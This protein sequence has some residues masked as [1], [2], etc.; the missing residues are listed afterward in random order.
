ML[1]FA[2]LLLGSSISG[3]LWYRNRIVATVVLSVTASGVIFYLLF[4]IAGSLCYECPYQ[5]PMSLIIRIIV[6]S[7][8]PRVPLV[9]SVT[10][11]F[12]G[13]FSWL[14]TRLDRIFRSIKSVIRRVPAF[15]LVLRHNPSVVDEVIIVPAPLFGD[16]LVNWQ[17]HKEDSKCVLW[18]MDTSADADVLLFAFRCAAD[19]V[20]Y[21]EIATLLCSRRVAALFFDCFLDGAVIPGAEE[22]ASYLA[23]ILTSILNIHACMGYNLEAT[24]QI[25]EGICSLQWEH[26]DPDVYIAWWSLTLTFHEQVLCCPPLR[27]D[28]SPGF[29]I[30]LSQMILQSIH[31][32]QAK[33]DD[34]IYSIVEFGDPMGQLVRGKRV[35]NAVFSNLVLTCAVSLGLRLNITDLHISDNSY[36]RCP[37]L[38][39]HFSVNQRADRYL[40]LRIALKQLSERIMVAIADPL[41]D[42]EHIRGVLRFLRLWI[43]AEFKDLAEYC[44]PWVEAIL[45]SGRPV[46]E[47]YQI[48]GA[49]LQ[50]LEDQPNPSLANRAFRRQDDRCAKVALRY[51]ALHYSV[52]G[53]YDDPSL[54]LYPAAATVALQIV[55]G[56]LPTQHP[57][58]TS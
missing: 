19:I 50:L 36:V 27:K 25:G 54:S 35:P 13:P 29:C 40:T 12:M 23:R 22:R 39:Y 20:W 2:L 51:L 48:A 44:M 21:P 53:L 15:T 30:W 45:D 24:H 49:A 32:R 8:S 17:Q 42:E 9:P 41:Y 11:P 47:R 28:T 4:T 7:L 33:R 38:T 14:L 1:Q 34:K 43:G 10:I 3:Y 16:K 56:L 18:T 37:F 5:T 57:K 58:R 6:P 52:S 55:R 26:E 46:S 31:W